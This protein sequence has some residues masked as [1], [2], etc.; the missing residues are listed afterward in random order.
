MTARDG[1][2]LRVAETR[3]GPPPDATVTM[4]ARGVRA[5][6]ARRAADHGDVPIVRGDR[7]AVAA[8]KAW[9]DRAR[10]VES[11]APQA[12]CVTASARDSPRRR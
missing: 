10:G 5:P 1:E 8:L 3:A 7:A 6:A 4:T 11:V 12:P 9:T 2:P